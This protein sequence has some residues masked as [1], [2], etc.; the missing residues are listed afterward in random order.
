MEILIVGAGAT[1]YL[2]WANPER[3]LWTLIYKDVGIH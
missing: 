1:A 2:K 3:K